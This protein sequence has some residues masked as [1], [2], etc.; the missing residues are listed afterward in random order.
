MWFCLRARFG[1][2]HRRL[3]AR[4]SYLLRTI[5]FVLHTELHNFRP[6]N[7]H[8]GPGSHVA[9]G[10]TAAFLGADTTAADAAQD[11][12]ETRDRS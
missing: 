7:I 12:P 8:P 6:G 1:M 4:N 10:D 3:C 2:W 11:I 5:S 9:S